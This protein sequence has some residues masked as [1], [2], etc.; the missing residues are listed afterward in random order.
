[1]AGAVRG[2]SRFVHDTSALFRRASSFGEVAGKWSKA[3]TRLRGTSEALYDAFAR[4]RVTVA[5][6]ARGLRVGRLNGGEFARLLRLGRG[7]EAFER[8]AGATI[9]GGSRVLRDAFRELDRVARTVMPDARVLDRA[10]HIARERDALVASGAIGATERVLTG[11][12]LL[13]VIEASPRLHSR[14]QQTLRK[15]ARTRKL[16]YLGGAITVGAI[17]AAYLVEEA[18]RHAKRSSG[19]FMYTTNSGGGAIR[20]C[21]VAGCSCPLGANER[22]SSSMIPC[23]EGV[24]WDRMRMARSACA[25]VSSRDAPYCVH[26]DTNESDADSV[27]FVDAGALP[28]DAY[29]QCERRDALDALHDMVSSTIDDISDPFLDLGHG[30]SESLRGSMRFAP[31]VILLVILLT[32]GGV[33]FAVYRAFFAKTTLP[34][35]SDGRAD[36]A[37]LR[38]RASRA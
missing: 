28:T 26:C 16:W 11:P 14:V 15:V 20:K 37:P 9:G 30:A 8:A 38:Y 5:R 35:S 34:S 32:L 27:D 3:L 1:M 36:D 29:V 6:G 2:L 31:I 12:R 18:E 23:D 21:R 25:S 4:L 17:G 7:A 24:L 33:L 19:C 22:D 10:T 13:R